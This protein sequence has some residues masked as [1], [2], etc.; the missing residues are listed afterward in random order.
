MRI[1]GLRVG[2]FVVRVR[3][4]K[5]NLIFDCRECPYGAS[6]ADDWACRFHAINALRELDA[7]IIVLA[8]VYERVYN[9]EQTKMLKEI[10]DL[11]NKFEA[12]GVW[13]YAHLGDPNV[14]EEA[15]F[16][17]RHDIIVRIAQD[18]IAYDPISA[19][20]TCLSEVKRETNRIRELKAANMRYA[21]IYLKNL[22]AIKK[23]F[24]NTRMIKKVRLLATKLKEFPEPEKVYKSLFEVE[25][26]PSFIG[27]RLVFGEEE[28]LELLDTYSVK[29][30]SV[31]IFE[32]PSK[33]QKIYILNT[34]EYTLPPSQYFILSKAREIV[35]TY[36]PGRTSLATVARSRKYFERIYQATIRDLCHKYGIEL[37]PDE[38]EALSRIV[39][40]YTVGYGILEILLSDRNITDIYI[41][42]PIGLKPI[43]IVHRNY[44]Q[45]ITNVLYSD[46]EAKAFVS[47]L[48]AMSGRPFDEAHP[49]LD[50]DL[51]DLETRVAVIGPPMAPDGVAFALRLH[52]VTPWTLPQFIDV[53]MLNPL[54]AGLLAFFIQNQS[55]MLICGSRGAGKTSLMGSLILE[56]LQNTRILVQE[57]TLEIPVPY[58]KNIG[59]N[60]QRLKTRSPIAAAGAEGEVAPEDALRTAL[61]LGDSAL[62]LGE[63]RSTEAKVLYEAMRVGAAGN[64]VMGTIHAD[65]AYA[66][67]D[68]VVNDLGVPTTS[69]KATDLV[70]VARPI[71]FGGSLKRHRRVI[72]ITEIKKHWLHDPEAEGGLLDLMYYEAK[73]DNLELL[74]DNLKESAI[75]QKISR[76][77]GLTYQ[78]VWDNI[79]VLG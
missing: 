77:T 43:Y 48:R 22:L 11:I 59:F 52:K 73:K 23:A 67:W 37:A 34:P 14:E 61:R 57:D 32:H 12:E 53:K 60:I 79:K 66:V 27:T 25:V 72:Q 4:A 55:T 5:K 17:E 70:V 21:E 62:I 58:M 30:A 74:E 75:F 78:G 68:R 31:Q 9:E 50:Y 3:A 20:L 65:S 44:G 1:G 7:D 18:L 6:L 29:D 51:Q 64:V 13:S 63:V 8:E 49:V 46:E 69:F 26:K 40:R 45:C 71:R 35:A 76:L 41:D 16:G 15:T 19:Y 24:E 39:A 33:P 42:S 2:P 28:K 54:A 56:I 47:K 38:I 36:K 10:A